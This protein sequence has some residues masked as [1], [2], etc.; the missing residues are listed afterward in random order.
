MSHGILTMADKNVFT[1]GYNHQQRVTTH[2]VVQAVALVLI[3]VAQSAI[4]INKDRNGYPHYQSTHSLFGL[5]T[6]LLT[7]SATF[8]GA[9]TKYSFQLRNVIK[10]AMLKTG[11]GFAGI[12][13]YMMAT[14][15]IFLGL[16][17]SWTDFD[18]LYVKLG[19]LVSFLI[20]SIYVTNK[21]FT[22]TIARFS[23]MKQK[24]K[25]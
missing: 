5:V 8:G 2:W 3:T 1:Q 15:T 24:S 18:D 21:S 4:Y 6:Y 23:E 10:P 14:T 11:H 16:N 20:T 13:V 17:Q 22:T 9:L 12:A 25:K 7:V 19:I